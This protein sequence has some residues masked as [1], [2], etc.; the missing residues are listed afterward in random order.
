MV[1][2]VYD[3]GLPFN[4]SLGKNLDNLIDR[5]AKKKA[6]LIIN[7]GGIGEGKT[8][9][10][11]EEADY[12]NK[13]YG[14][15]PINLEVRKHPQLALGGSEFLSKLRAC[16]EK[17]LPV[18][19]YDEAGD[20]NRRGALTRFNAMLNRTFETFRGFRIIV[21]LGL[22]SFRVLDNDLFDKNIP[23]LLIHL[24]DRK[25]TYG[26]FYA[27]SL[28]RMLYIKEKMKKLVVKPFAYDQVEP[29][30]RG[31]FLDLQ[32][33]RAKQLDKI[34]T[35]GKL[36]VLKKAEISVEG[37]VSYADLAKKVSRSVVWVKMVVNK[38][39]IKHARLI[40]RMKYFDG[41]VV[42]RLVDYLDDIDGQRVKGGK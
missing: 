21:I 40:N 20:F 19:I 14:L 18:I 36:D 6:S 30:F 1:R 10:M 11:V 12:I 16:Y 4:E 41:D 35:K 32:P 27:Y 13:S 33:E 39:K 2:Y 42:N 9:I 8:T 37:L 29:N 3:H 26:N 25:E 34:S 15:P 24:K 22:P 31:Q 17:K 5:V 38:L 7:D 28:Y 23:R